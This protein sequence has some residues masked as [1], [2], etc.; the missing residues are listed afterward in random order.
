MAKAFSMY[1][2]PSSNAVWGEVLREHGF[3]RRVIPTTCPDCYSVKDFCKDNPHGI[4]VLGASG[5]VVTAENGSY[6]DT[7]DSGDE[8]VIYFWFKEA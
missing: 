1:D 5:H 4:Y 6:F 3:K 7:W 8:I 2:M